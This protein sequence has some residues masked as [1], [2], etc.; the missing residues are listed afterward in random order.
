VYKIWRKNF[1]ELLSN[2]IFD[3]GS[4]LKPHP[5][6]TCM[7]MHCYFLLNVKHGASQL[8]LGASNYL[9]PALE[10][11]ICI[12]TVQIARKAKSE[13]MRLYSCKLTAL[14]LTMLIAVNGV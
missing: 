8:Y 1:Q 14:E 6:H 13:N 2:H 7:K 4:F 3:V 9:A 11:I 5:V 10:T 12:T